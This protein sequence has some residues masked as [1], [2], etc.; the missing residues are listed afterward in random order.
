MRGGHG[1]AIFF[2]PTNYFIANSA[3]FRKFVALWTNDRND[4]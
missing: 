4:P 2:T 3:L 1:E